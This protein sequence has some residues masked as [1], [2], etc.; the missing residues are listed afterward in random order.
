MVS[1]DE[2]RKTTCEKIDENDALLRIPVEL[3]LRLSTVFMYDRLVFVE[4]PSDEEILRELGRNLNIDTGRANVG[5]VYMKGVRN[6]AHFAA[7]G[8][9]DLLTRRKIKMWFITD[10]DERDD[11][12]VTRML[13]SLEDRAQLRVLKRR[14][15]E[16]Y[17][18][19][20]DAVRNFITEKQG[21]AG[22]QDPTP[23]LEDVKTA[24]IEEA[25][26]L[27]DEVIRLR[28]ERQILQPIFL[29]TRHV[30]GSIEERIQQAAKDLTT[31]LN[32]I[33]EERVTITSAIESV[34]PSQAQ[35]LAPGTLVLER[36]AKRFNV[37]FNKA[38]GDGARLAY[39]IPASAIADELQDLLQEVTHQ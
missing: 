1:R 10:R 33:E 30:T 11:S 3:G 22:I 21:A 8:T 19:V 6:F 16:N 27:K 36:V 15:L 25:S 23:S 24:I 29:Q 26:N 37:R 38:S 35:N 2:N 31:R 32:N 20:P 18:L 39:F 5:F 9:L 13:N 12:E 7:E 14:E 28:L 34:W 4:G 17:L